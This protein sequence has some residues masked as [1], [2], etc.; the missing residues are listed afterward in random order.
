MYV[1]LCGD[2]ICSL[3]VSE[4]AY[5]YLERKNNPP[6]GRLYSKYRN[7]KK[8]LIRKASIKTDSR[9]KK[10]Q[11]FTVND[12]EEAHI[13][14]LKSESSNMTFDERMEHW[15]GCWG[16]RNNAIRQRGGQSLSEQLL[17]DWPLYKNPDGHRFVNTPVGN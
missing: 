8:T 17:T 9:K 15:M 1:R 14:A 3:L 10:V 11:A 2:N 5:Y 16:T 13:C 7:W 12:D 4:Q 6:L